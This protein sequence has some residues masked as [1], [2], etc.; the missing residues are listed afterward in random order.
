MLM[1]FNKCDTD[2]QHTVTYLF[3]LNFHF[4]LDSL[5]PPVQF[6]LLD[7][8]WF[9]YF[10][11]RPSKLLFRGVFITSLQ[12]IYGRPYVGL[13]LTIHYFVDTGEVIH[14]DDDHTDMDE[15]EKCNEK[16]KQLW[17]QEFGM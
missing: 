7:I 8:L 2:I 17:I 9:Q 10:S 14:H 4:F 12:M 13:F 15:M 11:W 6:F 1:K 5:R 3:F 16:T